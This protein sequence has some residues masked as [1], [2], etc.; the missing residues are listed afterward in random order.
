MK[1]SLFPLVAI[2]QLISSVQL[3][4]GQTATQHQFKYE[5]Y[6]A[7]SGAL[8]RSSGPQ[9]THDAHVTSLFVDSTGRL[10]V[11]TVIGVAVCSSNQWQSRTFKLKGLPP[12]WQAAVNL[13]QI[14]EWGPRYI[15][16]GPP[17]TV[18]LAGRG[19][20]WRFRDNRYEEIDWG[21]AAPMILN[22]AVDNTGR[23]WIVTKE[24]VH[25]F[26]GENWSTMLR[27]YFANSVHRE[28][29]GLHSIAIGTNG[30]VWI[31]GTVY[32]E[33]TGPWEHEGPSWLIDQERKS[34]DE[35]PPMAPLFQ[36]D[37]KRWR[38]FGPP[39]GFRVKSASPMVD[40]EGK[41]ILRTPDGHYYADGEKRRRIGKTVDHFSDKQWSLRERRRGL[42]RGYS[43]L[44]F[45]DGDRSVEVL[46][47]DHRTGEVLNLQS[48]QL[49]LIR[50]AEDRYR[51]CL[52][53]GTTH[54][55]YRIW[56]ESQGT[57]NQ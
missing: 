15:A 3:S 22:I 53:L 18:W 19:G 40:A 46:P 37:G 27:P 45:R 26:D 55:L 10:W 32:G 50:I 56:A 42:L 23:V 21:S 30:T 47:R 14:S 16:E 36:Y 41:I 9:P 57:T 31:G 24:S 49:A 4:F 28:L 5:R 51:N 6:T 17:G 39:Q 12:R 20:V 7:E 35:G 54:G 1:S 29:P 2:A 11:G 48:E 44:L 33:L 52:W 8:Y 34:R 13:L 43:Q 25:T 38:A